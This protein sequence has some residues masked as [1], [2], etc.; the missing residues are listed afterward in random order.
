[1]RKFLLSAAAAASLIAMPAFAQTVDKLQYGSD[2][3]GAQVQWDALV[4]KTNAFRLT[5]DGRIEASGDVASVQGVTATDAA[6]GAAI[7]R[8]PSAIDTLQYGS[9]EPQAQAQWDAL[10]AKTNADR[11]AH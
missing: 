3:P 1:M 11:L 2:E 9:D 7:A 6:H 10:V 8:A 5:H 4:A